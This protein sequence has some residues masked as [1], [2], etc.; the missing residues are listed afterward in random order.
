MQVANHDA[1][2]IQDKELYR[3]LWCGV[4]GLFDGVDDKMAKDP[5]N[6]RLMEMLFAMETV[7]TAALTTPLAQALIRHHWN[8]VYPD[9]LFDRIVD[10]ATLVVFF[11][12]AQDLHTGEWI[13]RSRIF[14]ALFALAL[15]PIFKVI[16]LTIASWR[17]YGYKNF[18]FVCVLMNTYN[19][20]FM[21]FDFIT[22][23]VLYCALKQDASLVASRPE[24]NG[25]TWNN[26]GTTW[27]A[28]Q[29][30]FKNST[31]SN[32][33]Y[34]QTFPG[35][36]PVYLFIC[37]AT[38]WI[39][40]MMQMLNIEPI[41]RSILP[42][43]ESCRSKDTVVFMSYLLLASVGI[44]HAYYSFPIGMD[45]SDLGEAFT[46][47]FRLF[48]MGD[49][50]M[51]ELEGVDGTV[52]GSISKAGSGFTADLT[53]DDGDH[54]NFKNGIRLFAGFAVFL[55][56]IL[57]MNTFI[58]VLGDAYSESKNQ[59]NERFVRYR[60]NS[61]K[62]L[63]LRRLFCRNYLCMD[64]RNHQTFELG[65]AEGVWFRMPNYCLE[66]SS[67]DDPV[68]LSQLQDVQTDLADKISESVDKINESF[69]K[70]VAIEK[71]VDQLL[72]KGE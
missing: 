34:S 68:K 51:F 3:V 62:L 14:E 70:M 47:V 4:Q 44:F 25:T 54:T 57:F 30:P 5:W 45:D 71:K 72:L 23:M 8:V 64:F 28:M 37:I 46:R 69:V 39:Y 12:V 22:P 20:L 59:I 49:F 53:E 32:I 10:T 24:D 2:Y 7:P 6:T 26:S 56:P 17:V 52:Q 48:W 21:L 9:Y 40:L 29:A 58:T 65:K 61:L 43:W 1:G 11:F 41:G 50:D 18:R 63:L 13:P 15:L 27:D 42:V 31:D 38:R 60:T 67:A 19:N 16:T 35:I 55:G 36:H 33:Q 66:E